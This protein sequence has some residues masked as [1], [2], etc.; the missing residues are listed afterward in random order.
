M[1][2]REVDWGLKIAIGWLEDEGW[3]WLF[4]IRGSSWKLKYFILSF[5][6]MKVWGEWVSGRVNHW[7][8]DTGQDCKEHRTCTVL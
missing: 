7:F 8:Y 1:I 6:L 5:D 2:A 4:G 3:D